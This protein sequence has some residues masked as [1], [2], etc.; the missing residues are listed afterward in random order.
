MRSIT[1]RKIGTDDV[2]KAIKNDNSNYRKAMDGSVVV[3]TDSNWEFVG[4]NEVLPPEIVDIFEQSKIG[5]IIL[6]EYEVV[7]IE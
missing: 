4:E 2:I 5:Q 3:F 1:L 6:E 7:N